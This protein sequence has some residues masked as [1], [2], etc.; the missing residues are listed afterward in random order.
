MSTATSL[1]PRAGG[2]PAVWLGFLL[3]VA[4]VAIYMTL[5]MGAHRIHMPWYTLGASVVGLGLV[6]Y[7]LSQRRTFW[8]F[9]ALLLVGLL[10]AVEGWFLFSFTRNPTYA[11][12][13]APGTTFP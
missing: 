13:L 10:V 5:L 3:A 7:S 11:G 6:V 1:P 8:R 2:R 12:P 9:L 4:G